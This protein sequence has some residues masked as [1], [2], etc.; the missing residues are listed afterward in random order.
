MKRRRPIE[1][2]SRFLDCFHASALLAL[3]VLDKYLNLAG[4]RACDRS[5]PTW[6]I[7]PVSGLQ[8]Y[9]SRPWLEDAAGQFCWNANLEQITLKEALK[10]LAPLSKTVQNKSKN[11][12]REKS[13]YYQMTWIW[14]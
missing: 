3:A 6:K 2:V 14:R 12:F 10:T 7:N 4:V 11:N 9:F 8:L 1:S 13:S 5:S